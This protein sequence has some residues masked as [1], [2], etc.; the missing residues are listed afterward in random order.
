MSNRL[1]DKRALVTG[2]SR[3][4]GAAIAKRLAGEG[5]HVALTYVS[6]PE[7]AEATARVAQSLG[8]RALA[9]RA[10][11]TDAQ[12]VMDAVNLTVR[13]WGG[14]DI[15]VNNAGIAVMAASGW[16][17]GWRVTSARAASP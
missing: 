8:V 13:E 6:K 11:N 4:I 1:A 10:D 15:L 9:I 12:A 14:L 2:G 17:R 5:A 16:S 3:G 7:Q